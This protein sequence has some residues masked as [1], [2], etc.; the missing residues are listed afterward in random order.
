MKSEAKSSLKIQNNKR[1]I[2]LAVTS[3]CLVLFFKIFSARKISS[4]SY[5]KTMYMKCFFSHQKK[6]SS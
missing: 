3:R 6:T 1:Q 2:F 5:V 4:F